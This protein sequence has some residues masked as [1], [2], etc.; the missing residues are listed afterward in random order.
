M[1]KNLNTKLDIFLSNHRFSSCISHNNE[2]I[3]QK[4][5]LEKYHKVVEAETEILPMSA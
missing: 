2:N 3:Q 4:K 5:Q 1:E